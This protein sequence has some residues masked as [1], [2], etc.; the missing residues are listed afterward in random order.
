MLVSEAMTW[1]IR[2]A[3]PD[4]TIEAAAK[5]MAEID[6]GVLL[7]LLALVGGLLDVEV[8]VENLL[9]SK[10]VHHYL[11]QATGGDVRLHDHEYDVVDWVDIH[12]ATASGRK[13][14]RRHE[15][16]QQQPVHGLVDVLDR[17]EVDLPV[18]A[19][20]ELV[21]RRQPIGDPL[22]EEQVDLRCATP[23]P[24]L[25]VTRGHA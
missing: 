10:A 7:P 23:D 25:K 22:G 20:E 1:D 6:A 9:V 12:E 16:F 17:R 4:H 14:P 24:A 13:V 19:A 8:P 3:S 15:R 5:I 21:V 2:V 18:P 11:M